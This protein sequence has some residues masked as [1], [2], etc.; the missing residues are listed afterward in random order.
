M[1]PPW[2]LQSAEHI[3]WSCVL[4]IGLTKVLDFFLSDSQK[5]RVKEVIEN[6][7]LWLAAREEK[8]KNVLKEPDAPEKVAARSQGV[9]FFVRGVH[10]LFAI[11]ILFSIQESPGSDVLTLGFPRIFKWQAAVDLVAIAISAL[12]IFP[13][14]G[15]HLVQWLMQKDS[16]WSIVWRGTAVIVISFVSFA[17]LHSAEYAVIPHLPAINSISP[18]LFALSGFGG[19]V[20][21]SLSDLEHEV[22]TLQIKSLSL[23]ELLM[24]HALTAILAAPLIILSLLGA[25]FAMTI[26]WA[27]VV[28]GTLR[29]LFLGALFLAFRVATYPNGPL[30][31]ITAILGGIAWLLGHFAGITIP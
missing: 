30:A 9:K 28:G 10:A 11:M 17:A 4:L 1:M 23:T 29:L 27:I 18:K 24:I 25:G 15:K 12:V 31:A 6:L 14:F 2:V 21:N 7:W 8:A 22:Q 3:A 13:I 5:R 20:Y 26:G 16:F 19:D